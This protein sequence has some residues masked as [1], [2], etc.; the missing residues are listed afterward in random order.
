MDLYYKFKNIFFENVNI[1]VESWLNFGDEDALYFL[2]FE[3]HCYVVL[4]LKQSNF[5]YIADGSNR[6]IEVIGVA[7][8]IRRLLGIR[9]VGC[10]IHQKTRIDYCSSSAVLI[11]LELTKNYRTKN[12]LIDLIAPVERKERVIKALHKYESELM[13]LPPLHE[14]RLRLVCPY[15]DITYAA[16]RSK[17]FSMHLRNNHAQIQ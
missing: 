1:K 8:D 9:L 17:A 7:E 5:G 12:F 13:D 2:G 11:A 3:S 15:C 4:Y 6:Y 16:K 14:R 10:K